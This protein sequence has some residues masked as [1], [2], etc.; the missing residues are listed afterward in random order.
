MGRDRG[1][2]VSVRRGN[3]TLAVDCETFAAKGCG[4]F[5][6]FG[7][8]SNEESAGILS[9]SGRMFEAVASNY[10]SVYWSVSWAWSNEQ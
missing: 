2:E 9:L 5:L 10:P 4:S 1:L 8:K 3:D 7:Q 6:H